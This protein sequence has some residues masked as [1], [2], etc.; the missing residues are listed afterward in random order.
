MNPLF[1]RRDQAPLNGISRSATESDGIKLREP[2]GE[3]TLHKTLIPLPL[4]PP[5]SLKSRSHDRV[6]AVA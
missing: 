6:S 4:R 1:A 3:P 5:P 2:V